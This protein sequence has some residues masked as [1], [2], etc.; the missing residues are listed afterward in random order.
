VSRFASGPGI[1]GTTG[2]IR[3]ATI[4][5][6]HF[7][8][9]NVPHPLKNKPSDQYSEADLANKFG[10]QQNHIWSLE[11]LKEATT[12]VYHH[13]PKTISDYVMR[14]IMNVLCKTLTFPAIL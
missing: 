13:K 10:R 6:A 4:R 1:Y 14:T 12:V 7:R 3:N 5:N 11:E 8:V 9:T 2:S